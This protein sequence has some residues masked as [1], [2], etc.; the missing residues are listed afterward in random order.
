MAV[1]RS[2][3]EAPTRATALA[4]PKPVFFFAPAQVKKRVQDWGPRAYQERV[5]TAL[6]GFVGWSAEWLKVQYSQGAEA[7]TATWREAHAG[8]VAPDVGHIVTLW[9]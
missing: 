2:H 4:G 3:H 1:G 5:A 6:R 9:D 7:A 8:R